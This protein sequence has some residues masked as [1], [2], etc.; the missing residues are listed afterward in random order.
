VCGL[1]QLFGILLPE[2]RVF[3]QLYNWYHPDYRHQEKPSDSP[4]LRSLAK[5]LANDNPLL[6]ECPEAMSN[7]HWSQW[8]EWPE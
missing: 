7:I 4:C 3:L 8:P 6:Y 1:E 5:A 2:L